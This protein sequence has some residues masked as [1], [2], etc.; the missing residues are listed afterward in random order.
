V[1]DSGSAVRC[2]PE[3]V[4][5]AIVQ[6]FALSA[7]EMNI[8]PGVVNRGDGKASDIACDQ[9][10]HVEASKALGVTWYG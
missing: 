8:T 4:S 6:F 5:Y 3:H 9:M 2:N 10:K 1:D 7:I